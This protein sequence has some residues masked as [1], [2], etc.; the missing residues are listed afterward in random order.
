MT[1]Q[2]ETERLILKNYCE[3]DLENIYRLK[4]EPSVWKFSNK[5]ATNKIEDSKSSLESLLKNYDKNKRDFQALFLKKSGKYI[6]E[7]GILTFN[8]QNNRAVVGYNLLPEH[9]NKG[10]ATEITK[11]LVKYLF[12]DTKTERIEA[13]ALDSN[14]ASRKVLEKSGFVLEGLLR[15]FAYI[16]NRYFNVCYFGIIRHDYIIEDISQ[17]PDLLFKKKW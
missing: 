1:I 11:A 12:E 3:N 14:T 2:I 7:A 16:N 8:N 13:L 4:S 10:Y 9:W 15:N 17:L 6:G 5:I